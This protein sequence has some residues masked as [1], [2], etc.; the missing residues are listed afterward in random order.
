MLADQR[1]KYTNVILLRTHDRAT[2][3]CSIESIIKR[4]TVLYAPDNRDTAGKRGESWQW[5]RD[6]NAYCDTYRSK[7]PAGFFPSIHRATLNLS[8][9]HSIIIATSCYMY[10]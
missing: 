6:S 4:I 8:S 1:N 3:F 9:K 7:M 2:C 5:E 10:N